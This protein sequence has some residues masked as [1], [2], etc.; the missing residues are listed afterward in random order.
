LDG[1]AAPEGAEVVVGL[2]EDGALDLSPEDE[3][4]LRERVVEIERGDYITAEELL[5][6]LGR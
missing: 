3:A 6:R 2:P 5:H 4:E 1:A